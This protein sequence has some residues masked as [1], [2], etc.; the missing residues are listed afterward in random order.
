MTLCPGCL[1]LVAALPC[2]RCDVLSG[3]TGAAPRDPLQ[4]LLGPT[5]GPAEVESRG[6]ERLDVGETFAGHYVVREFLG[7]GAFG[8]VYRV[9][10]RR[11][12]V[13]RALKVLSPDLDRAELRAEARAALSLSHPHLLRFFQVEFDPPGPYL[14]MEAIDGGNLEA[15][16]L[17]LGGRL[18]LDEALG[19]AQATL[20]GLSFLHDQ[21]MVHLDVKPEN[22]LLDAGRVKLTDYGLARSVRAQ[23]A[24]GGTSGAGTLPYMPPE[25]VAG[26]LCDGR[27]DVYAV[28]MLLVRLLTGAFPFP[29]AS[30]EGVIRWHRSGD[31]AEL[32]VPA[33]LQP[34]LA[35]ALAPRAVDRF[36]TAAALR[37]ALT[38]ESLEASRLTRRDTLV[39][40]AQSLGLPVRADL[41]ADTA[42]LSRLEKAIARR[43]ASA[44]PK[45]PGAPRD[46]ASPLLD[47]HGLRLV[48]LSA[49]LWGTDRALPAMLIQ[50]LLGHA[51]SGLSWIE[52]V[53][54][55]NALSERAGLPPAYRVVAGV[56]VR[57]LRRRGGYRLP[58]V[59]E[60]SGA[61][62]SVGPE[63]C[64]DE[65]P[66]GR[67]LLCGPGR[68]RMPALPTERRAGWT[69]KVVRKG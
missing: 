53:R 29:E 13:D 8:Q 2:S 26:G 48:R 36:P 44:A 34:V 40:R 1:T 33:D 32:G 21:G 59:A 64:W 25:Q 55:C 31:R 57:W 47:R 24:A 37:D 7:G 9:L 3:A 17:Q 46:A 56:T 51:P 10:D 52:A 61:A 43:A 50:E 4:D 68:D 15:R 67:R 5:A 49:G 14:V 65:A 66:G 58:T 63:W 30:R 11:L 39:Q 41:P 12:G 69:L 23:L 19:V 35:R 27:A 6:A 45:K 42:T 54:V 22:I 18:P 16:R 62:Q 60:W 38:A 28:G 20:E